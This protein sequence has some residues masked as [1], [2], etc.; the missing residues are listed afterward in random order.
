MHAG[1]HGSFTIMEYGENRGI[2]FTEQLVCATYY[3]TESDL[4][5]YRRIMTSL[6]DDLRVMIPVST[7][8]EGEEG[9]NRITF[10]FACLPTSVADPLERLVCVHSFWPD[11]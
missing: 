3:Q 7:R 4:K 11:R 9:G 1:M 6:L 10:C 8:A 2:V 5:A